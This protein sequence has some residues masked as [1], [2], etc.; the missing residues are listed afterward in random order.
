MQTLHCVTSHTDLNANNQE[1]VHEFHTT[2]TSLVYIRLRALEMFP[3]MG[4]A[5]PICSNVVSGIR[6]QI[7]SRSLHGTFCLL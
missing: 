4:H 3:F 5:L 2:Y 6:T 7:L 1:Y